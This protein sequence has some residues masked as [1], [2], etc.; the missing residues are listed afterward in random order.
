M[1]SFASVHVSSA[2]KTIVPW[3]VVSYSCGATIEDLILPDTFKSVGIRSHNCN[4][5]IEKVY[6]SAYKDDLICIHCGSPSNLT[7]PNDSETFYPYCSDCSSLDRIQ[8]P[9]VAVVCTSVSC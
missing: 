1:A 6:Y 5:P 2:N 7:V 3:S 4:D 9:A 8:T